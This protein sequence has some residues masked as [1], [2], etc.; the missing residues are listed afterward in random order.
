MRRERIVAQHG[1]PALEDV[2]GADERQPGEH[3]ERDREIKRRGGKQE[4]KEKNNR[5]QHRE[6]IGDKARA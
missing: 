6:R 4:R 5:D 2:A 1:M 3:R